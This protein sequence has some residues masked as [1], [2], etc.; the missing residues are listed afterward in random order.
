MEFISSLPPPVEI[1]Q[2]R[3]EFTYDPI[4]RKEG[5]GVLRRWAMKPSVRPIAMSIVWAL[6]EVMRWPVPEG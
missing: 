5:E 6:R 4:I 3:G 2:R 1:A